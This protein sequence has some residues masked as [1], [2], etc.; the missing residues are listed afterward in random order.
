MSGIQH[1]VE[2]TSALP[3]H[4]WTHV[5]TTFD[6]SMLQLYVNGVLVREF[7]LSR[8]AATVSSGDLRIGGNAIWDE[9][10]KGR[11][12]EVRIYNR[13]LSPAEIQVN[14]GTPVP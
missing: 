1:A 10:F 5:V 2:G 3:L 7:G 12:D 13:A 4:T 11:I 9:Y 14:M 8:A 6:G